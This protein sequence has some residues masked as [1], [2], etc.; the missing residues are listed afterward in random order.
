MHDTIVIELKKALLLAFVLWLLPLVSVAGFVRP[1]VDSLTIHN[2]DSNKVIA[3]T[4]STT[5]VYLDPPTI[6]GTVVGQEFTVNLNIR[7]AQ[8]VYSWQAGMVFNPN[9]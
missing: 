6:N 3:Q 7:D 2:I 8:D 5:M 1:V 4:N 9:V